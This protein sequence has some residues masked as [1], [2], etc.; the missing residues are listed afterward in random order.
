MACFNADGQGIAI[1]SPTSGDTWNFGPHANAMSDD[2]AGGPCV[3]IA[4]ISLVRLGPQSTYEYR[5][6][7]IV[8]DRTTISSRL[9]KLWLTYSKE[10][11]KVTDKTP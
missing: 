8:G 1:F 10:R 4:P 7:L 3:H 11:G 2:P 9:E 5:Y 6:W